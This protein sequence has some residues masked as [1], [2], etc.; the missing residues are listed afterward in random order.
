MSARTV[1]RTHTN[2]WQDTVAAG[3]AL[4]TS[5]RTD[6][7]LLS[8]VTAPIP[9]LVIRCGVRSALSFGVARGAPPAPPDIDRPQEPTWSPAGGPIGE[10]ASPA[11]ALDWRHEPAQA[12]AEESPESLVG[13][14]QEPVGAS[15]QVTLDSAVDQSQETA[16]RKLEERGA[17]SDQPEAP[18]PND[19][20]I[21]LSIDSL[22]NHALSEPIPVVISSLGEAMF[23]ASMRDL[24]LAATGNSIGDALLL[25]KE[26]IDATVEELKR[27][28]SHLTHDE[29]ER[30]QML[31][32]YIR[33]DQAPAK[34]RWF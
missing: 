1:R 7:P 3:S 33:A 23:T 6:D 10:Q 16:E 9:M 31:L 24:D 20:R 29:R 4:T 12:E 8:V 13:Q 19:T 22:P 28:Q 25:L 18:A 27:R 2:G 32:T 21:D 26:Q 15:P 11:P 5:I 30:L 34:S 17:Q 14:L